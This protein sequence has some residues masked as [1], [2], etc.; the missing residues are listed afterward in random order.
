MSVFAP[1]LM[2]VAA[3]LADRDAELAA[4]MAAGDEAALR[5]AYQLLAGRVRAVAMRVLGS[6]VEAD[7]VVQETFVEVWR[8][9]RGFDPARGS[10]SAWVTTIGHHR[11]VDRLR[12]RSVAAR[13]SAQAD[14]P[15]PGGPTAHDEV[16]AREMRDLVRQALD[17][18]PREQRIAVELMYFDGLSQSEVADRLGQPLGTIKGRVRAAMSKLSGLLD[19]LAP[20]VRA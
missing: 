18:L 12:S 2:A 19:T 20:A 15:E 17:S 10:L 13:V 6:S 11:A 7:D 14:P 3:H 5:R 8:H 4:R 1:V 9:A 16:E